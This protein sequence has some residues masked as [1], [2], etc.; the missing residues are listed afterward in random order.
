[1]ARFTRAGSAAES[2]II[3]A[4][5]AMITKKMDISMPLISNSKMT[6]PRIMSISPGW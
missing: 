3:T 1:V 2:T 5:I 4:G 6:P